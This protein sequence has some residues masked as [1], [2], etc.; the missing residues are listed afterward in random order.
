M[1]GSFLLPPLVS[2]SGGELLAHELLGHGVGRVT[3]SVGAR[4]ADSIQLTNLFMR[5]SGNGHLQRDGTSHGG[6][7]TSAVSGSVPARLK[8]LA[9]ARKLVLNAIPFLR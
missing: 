4:H 9:I 2:S 3:G 6:R 8:T 5:V 7:L 1:V